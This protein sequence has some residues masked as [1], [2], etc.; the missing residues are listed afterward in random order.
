[1][2]KAIRFLL[3][4]LLFTLAWCVAVYSISLFFVTSDNVIA[5]IKEHPINAS[6]HLIGGAIALIIAPCQLWSGIQNRM[7]SAHRL[8]G[9]IYCFAVLSSAVS[10]IY[11]SMHSKAGPIGDIGFFLLGIIWIITLW[12][13]MLRLKQRNLPAHKYWMLI[14]ISLTYAAVTLR[15]TLPI[16]LGVMKLEPELVLTIVA[17]SCWLPQIILVPW[18]SKRYLTPTRQ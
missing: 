3:W 7:R 1:M 13:G 14:N 11:L 5:W 16:L 15:L 10:G 4:F 17:W 18:I 8:A 2:L 9:Y 12:L 6:V